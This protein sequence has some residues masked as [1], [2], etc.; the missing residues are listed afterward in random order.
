ME[1]LFSTRQSLC[2]VPDKKHLAKSSLPLQPLTS[3]LCGVWQ[4]TKPLL[5]AFGVLPV[6]PVV[7]STMLT[8]VEKL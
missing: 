6:N 4:S 7:N 5:S 8:R 3:V 1:C 2:R